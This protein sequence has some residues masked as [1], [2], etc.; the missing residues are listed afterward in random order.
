MHAGGS[1]NSDECP[2]TF[3]SVCVCINY[4]LRLHS[5]ERMDMSLNIHLDA[6]RAYR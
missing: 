5:N 4:P 3:V 2:H 6:V 1:A